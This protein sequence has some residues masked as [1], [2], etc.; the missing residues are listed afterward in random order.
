MMTEPLVLLLPLL[1]ALHRRLPRMSSLITEKTPTNEMSVQAFG[2]REHQMWQ[3]R[4]R[5]I[6]LTV[7][8]RE[9]THCRVRIL[10]M[11]WLEL[12]V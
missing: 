2:V 12:R 7:L 3:R 5:V 4:L 9:P 6:E 8:T 1:G 11:H 10:G